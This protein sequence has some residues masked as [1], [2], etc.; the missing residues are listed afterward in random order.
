MTN[1]AESIYDGLVPLIVGVTGH[2]DLVP[3]QIPEIRLRVRSFL[4]ALQERF[5]DRHVL[6]MS[7]L[8]EGADRLVAQEALKL[9]LKIAV[10]LPMPRDLYVTD[11]PSEASRREF[12]E[13]CSRA[14]AVYE[15]P[16]IRGNAAEDLARYG[17]ERDLQ[18]AQLGVFL[19]AHSHIVLALWDGKL[20]TDVGGTAQVVRFHHDDVM[21]GYAESDAVSQQLLADDESDLV[22]HIVVSRDRPDGEPQEMVLPTTSTCRSTWVLACP[23]VCWPPVCCRP[24]W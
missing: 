8:A 19:C 15:L 24:F 1:S 6:V 13:L 9:G 17:P 22:Y 3:E 16:V 7:P 23:A 12:D 5:A 2:R 21:V 20:T 14:E 11:F 4:V 10:P 18:Y